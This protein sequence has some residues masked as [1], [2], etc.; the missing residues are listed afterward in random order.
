MFSSS[1]DISVKLSV[2]AFYLRVISS[3]H[4]TRTIVHTDSLVLTLS[5]TSVVTVGPPS[6]TQG[7]VKGFS[8]IYSGNF[9]FEAELGGKCEILHFVCV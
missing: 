4:H 1:A 9:I 3:L 8:L 7:E 6:E 2:Y 5:C